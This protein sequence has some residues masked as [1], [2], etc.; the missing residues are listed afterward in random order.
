VAAEVDRGPLSSPAAPPWRSGWLGIIGAGLALALLAVA[1]VQ[2]RQATLLNQTV[3]GDDYVVLTVYQAQTEYL[4]LVN[5]W[6]R[7]MREA[8]AVERAP[9]QLR[10][11]VWVSRVGLLHNERTRRALTSQDDFRST[12][13]QADAFIAKA[14]EV[15]GEKPRRALTTESDR[16]S[17][18]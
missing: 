18:V 8:G 6:E 9:L 5:Q 2:G 12:L 14:D 1:L 10:Y 16:K 17:V 7:T 4:R 13:A 11:D 3:Q 15:L